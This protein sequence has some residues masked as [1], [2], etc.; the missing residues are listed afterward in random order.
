MPVVKAIESAPLE[1]VIAVMVG[2]PGTCATKTLV[3]VGGVNVRVEAFVAASAIVPEFKSIGEAD[4]MPS[5]SISFAS[6]ATVYL[7]TRAVV[8]L[9]E[10]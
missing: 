9:P 7:N 10:T 6:V 5:V 2:A 3:I 1:V 8:P 4:T